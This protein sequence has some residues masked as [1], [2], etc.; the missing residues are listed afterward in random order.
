MLREVNNKIKKKLL[1]EKV[2]IN[3][4]IRVLD[5]IEVYNLYLSDEVVTFINLIITT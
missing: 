1:V 5:K 2:E 4:C 3:N